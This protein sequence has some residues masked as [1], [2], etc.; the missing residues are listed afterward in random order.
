MRN[1]KL[2]LEY[3]GSHFFG[4]QRQPKHLTVQEA[5]E[6]ALSKLFDTKTKIQAATSRTDTG[7]HARCQVVTFKCDSSLPKEP[8]LRGLN[9]LLPRAIAIKKI[10]EVPASFHAR[11]NAKKKEYEYCIWNSPIRSPL[12]AEK[13]WHVT[14]PLDMQ[15]MK[16]A[17]K[18]FLGKQDFRSFCASKTSVK[19]TVRTVS[20][21]DLKRTGERIVL[22]IQADGFLYHMV[23]NIVGTL[24]EIGRGNME[25]EK[26]TKL[27]N[28][29]DRTQAGPTAPALGLTLVRV[30]Y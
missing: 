25:V 6:T 9:A 10:A 28:L 24:V 12:K 14:C 1:I 3:D 22:R 27:L 11:Y 29:K 26:V 16:E 18:S 7:V 5:L 17:C 23:R 21:M 2:T 8:I 13:A 4:F 15:K 20:K 30:T 19:T